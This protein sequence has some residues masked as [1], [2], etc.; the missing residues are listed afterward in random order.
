VEI[1]KILGWVWEG[2]EKW[3]KGWKYN[4]K[5]WTFSSISYNPKLYNSQPNVL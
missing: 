5:G 1:L 3:G 4:M 2:W